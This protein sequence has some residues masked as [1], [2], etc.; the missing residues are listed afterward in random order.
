MLCFNVADR[1]AC[2]LMEKVLLLKCHVQ[3]MY[4]LLPHPIDDKM[5]KDVATD[6]P[7]WSLMSKWQTVP[8]RGSA[9]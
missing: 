6:L 8:A 4:I 5:C 3:E 9:Q 1:H 2:N 7:P